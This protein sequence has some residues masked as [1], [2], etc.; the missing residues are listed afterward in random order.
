MNLLIVTF[1]DKCSAK[2]EILVAA[3]SDE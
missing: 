1:D 3:A 2:R